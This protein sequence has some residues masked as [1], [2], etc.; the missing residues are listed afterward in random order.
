M[1]LLEDRDL[2]QSF[3]RLTVNSSVP[4]LKPQSALESTG[5]PPCAA[6]TKAVLNASLN[7][8]HLHSELEP[9]NL[10]EEFAAL[11]ITTSEN[12]VVEEEAQRGLTEDL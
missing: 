2:R 10:I 11:R 3:S 5:Y 8:Q 7:A 4:T 9:L 6:T 12:K 1:E